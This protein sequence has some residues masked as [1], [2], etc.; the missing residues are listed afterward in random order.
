MPQPLLEY[1][2]LA[3]LGILLPM[4]TGRP[5]R[6]LVS[7]WSRGDETRRAL[8]SSIASSLAL[9][10]S[11]LVVLFLLEVLH[12]DSGIPF[13]PLAG[14]VLLATVLGLV[15]QVLRLPSH[16]TFP[17][18]LLLASLCYFLGYG[19]HPSEG[20]SWHPIAGA[21]LVDYPVTMLF[22]LGIMTTF[23][24]IDR[25]HRLATGVT[26]IMS[27]S[28]M[29]LVLNWSLDLSPVLLGMIGA[30]CLGHLFLV[31]GDRRLRL[32][33]AGQLQLALLLGAGTVASR[34]WGFTVPLL[35]FPLVA[36]IL[37]IFDRVYDGLHRL[38]HGLESSGPEHLRSLLLDVGLSERWIVFLAWALT[39]EAGVMMNLL[40]EARSLPLAIVVVLSHGLLLVLGIACLLRMGDRLEKQSDP[41][42]LRILFLS[43]YFEPEVNAP[44]TRLRENVRHWTAL[45]HQVTIICPVPSAP[46]G[47]PYPGYSNAVW[48]E[49][50]IGGARVIRVWTFVA[51]NRGR[52]RRTLNYFS[53]MAS[54]LCALLFVR[55]HDVL[56]ATTPQFFCGLAGAIASLPRKER[57]VLE[58]RD[59]WPES[60][61][62]VGAARG[63][64]SLPLRL[65]AGL[66]A[67]MYRRADR[68]VT[69]GEGYREH[70]LEKQPGIPPARIASIPNGIDEALA[71]APPPP[72]PRGEKFIV[73]YVGTIGMAHGLGVVLRA[74]EALRER[75][76]ILFLLAGDGAE[77]ERL[78]REAAARGLGNVHFTGLLDKEGVR[79]ELEKSSACLVH[80]RRH[81]LF[82]TVLPS[83]MFEA[84]GMARPVLLGVEGS[85]AAVLRRSGGGLT[86]TPEDGGALA[87]L[88]K[89]LAQDPNECEE[90]GRRGRD[91][92]I[93]NF[94]REMFAR[95]YLEVMV[96]AE[97]AVCPPDEEP[98]GRQEEPR[99]DLAPVSPN[100]GSPPC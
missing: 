78:Q 41:G 42:K 96:S 2:L 95:Q 92:V 13:L 77:R 71:T 46:H 81:P 34:S 23:N 37:P 56:V 59:L 8:S 84:M 11:F 12:P 63:W 72:I 89:R 32:G 73:S 19:F 22:Y 54:S 40:Y 21:A 64:A 76:D 85:C 50:N 39:M 67:W 28:L 86:F 57:F 35:A 43:H 7:V 10:T 33:S 1:L 97:S 75:E 36:V 93:R 6:T 3:L 70:L 100:A 51:A 99:G 20:L 80:L 91:F 58:V 87:A 69:V 47:R 49:E 82:R 18:R 15:E 83:K 27:L 66:A 52:I 88:V 26:M 24:I 31:Q 94:R 16:F 45:G 17:H 5:L 79:R 68:I 55:R 29:A 65:I 62:A 14:L 48:T 38:G 53:F 61:V 4:V 30:V 25:L 44:A 74:A 60:I 9:M 90:M 98:T